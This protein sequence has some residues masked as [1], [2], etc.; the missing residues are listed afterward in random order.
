VI[1]SIK[2]DLKILIVYDGRVDTSF[3]PN[4]F[5]LGPV[6]RN[7]TFWLNRWVRVIVSVV[8][9]DVDS[10]PTQY[11]VIST[12]RAAVG[13]TFRFDQPGF[14]LD[15]YDQIWLFGDRPAGADD[16]PDNDADIATY[17]L[18]DNELRV[19]ADW[20]DRG[21]GVFATGDHGILGASLASRIPRVR[22][23]RRW[24]HAQAVPR[25]YGR[26]MHQTYNIRKGQP[27]GDPEMDA[28]PQP[29]YLVNQAGFELAERVPHPLLCGLD[30]PIDRFPDH[31]HEGAVFEDDEVSLDDLLDIPGYGGVEFP[32]AQPDPSAPPFR[33]VPRVIAHVVTTYGTPKAFPALAV[34]DGDPVGRG[35]IV[36]DSTWHHWFSMNVLPFAEDNAPVWDDL[37]Q[38]QRNVAVWLATPEQRRAMLITTIW[39]AIITAPPMRFIRALPLKQVGVRALDVL[40]RDAPHCVTSELVQSFDDA[41]I[42]AVAP[43]THRSLPPGALD[44]LVVGGI[45][46]RLHALAGDHL[47]R[48]RAGQRPQIDFDQVQDAAL[49]G[50]NDA[51]R[52]LLADLDETAADIDGLRERY[53]RSIDPAVT[54]RRPSVTAPVGPLA[55]VLER[56]EPAE[57]TDPLI[58]DPGA[59][60][61]VHLDVGRTRLFGDVVKL[62]DEPREVA[63]V[64]VQ[65]GEELTMRA[66]AD[67]DAIAGGA[68][69]CFADTLSDD[70]NDWIGRHIPD[71]SHRLRIWYRIEPV[72][73]DAGG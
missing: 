17:A 13:P 43:S 61:I 18:T 70:A 30:G 69:E 3:E 51:R 2:V 55:I 68:V 71:P 11:P 27:P 46:R 56:V 45:A 20:M 6:I 8:N 12:W 37:Q 66:A 41:L 21:G 36:V 19:I 24:T 42:R 49:A 60:L 16:D 39:D 15:D 9:R 72:H 52:E 32:I 40:G 1:G 35:R 14:N 29:L 64:V 31:M 47:E 28:H 63:R 4:E 5:G 50:L 34:W 58:T 53:S 54:G 7:L 38:F 59:R 26:T 73:A 65:P 62:G 22:K 23:M 10:T 44:V 57:L 25:S 67:V 48:L 33:P